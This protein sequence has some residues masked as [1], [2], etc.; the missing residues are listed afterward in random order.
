MS[1]ISRAG[2]PFIISPTD[3]G[4]M[5]TNN[6]NF[7]KNQQA[8]ITAKVIDFFSDP[9][10]LTES[11]KLLIKDA[12]EKSS[13]VNS[14]PINSIWCQIIEA[15]RLDQHIAYPFF[16]SHLCLPVKPTEQVWVF[17]A[18]TDQ[19]YYWVCRKPGDYISEDV[20]Y[21]HIDR[22][23]NRPVVQGQPGVET[24][25][26]AKDAF[27]GNVTNTFNFPQGKTNSVYEKTSGIQIDDETIINQSQEYQDNFI[28]EPVPRIVKQP[29]DFIIQGS[30][31]TSVKLG[32]STSAPESGIID[33]V[34]GRF[35]MTNPVDNTRNQQEIDK[36][37]PAS[38]DG[39]F[40]FFNDL[41]RVYLGMNENVDVDFEVKINGINGS[42]TGGC[43]VV[44]SDQVRLI[45]NNDV[46][47]TVGNTGA[48]IVI[49]SDGN[50]VIIP[51]DT[52]VIK[53]GGED[54]N[55]AILCQ[56]AVQIIP[57]SVEAPS[58]ISTAGG[59]IG[60]SEI[61]GTGLFASKIL[62]K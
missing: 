39:Q 52:G 57:G 15:N 1:I 43:V 12:V 47:I 37:K 55:K 22:I 33:I 30:N 54:A 6:Q 21:T 38:F 5:Q 44:K 45:A 16:P 19:V 7:G 49:K 59:I 35:V 26:S 34:T 24:Q 17:Y 8:F 46:K 36:T 60:A 9:K 48:G 53:L 14:M 13:L 25:M 32:S 11:K 18:E 3:P 40:D 61:I 10:I 62:V 50:I 2:S 41:A 28:Q 4:G 31:N 20:N 51:S 58:I 42:G 56:E 23:V 27:N 29:G